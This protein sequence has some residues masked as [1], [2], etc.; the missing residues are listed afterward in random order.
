MKYGD[1][2]NKTEVKWGKGGKKPYLKAKIG[3]LELFDPLLVSLDTTRM[4]Q[5]DSRLSNT[6][7]YNF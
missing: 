3:E 4:F 2:D 5:A 1:P 6:K 7:Y